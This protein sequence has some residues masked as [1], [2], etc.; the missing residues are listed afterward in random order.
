VSVD[1]TKA[2]VPPTSASRLFLR[3]RIVREIVSGS[4]LTTVLAIVCALI[5]GGVLIAATDP[6]VAA[7][8]PYFF[9]RPAD[10]LGALGQAVGGAYASLFQGGIWDVTRPGLE[11]ISSFAAS[12]GFATPLVAAGLGIALA[13]R[14][15]EF[16]IGGQ[17]QV[18][19]GGALAGWV[20]F[21]LH[22]PGPLTLIV[23]IAAAMA[24]GALWAGLAGLLKAT[25][26]AHEVIVTIML[27]YV[28]F[29][30][31][32]YALTTPLLKAPGSN[33][34]I[35]PA[36]DASATFPTLFGSAFPLQSAFVLVV[37]L[38]MC[39]SVLLQ[40]TT[41]GF[42]L[43][44]VGENARAA[45][46]AGMRTKRIAVLAMMLSGALVGVA[47]AYQVLAQTPTG[48][49]AG[50]D[51]G[52]GF[53]ALTVALLG[54][55]RP[56]GVLAA[57]ILFGVFQAGGYT[58]QAVNGID[59]SIV[60]VVQSVIVLFVAAPPLVR[61]IFRLPSPGAQDGRSIA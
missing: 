50:F 17:G 59:I 26:G 25:T 1:L 48:F 46:T 40:R 27:N 60:T 13:F 11:G 36:E 4:G 22:L 56:G 21:S 34:P 14:A 41:L 18:L 29:Y 28:A 31:L 16:N 6:R 39:V 57:G 55:S 38:T 15:G 10:T 5:V 30:L 47:G 9:A 8:L 45:A 33:N 58:M 52:V 51:A 37:V 19:A 35:S 49:T 43:R 7:A 53:N 32:S 23:A 44:A 61:G 20:G 42:R 3:H 24:G 12:V 54:R 2:D